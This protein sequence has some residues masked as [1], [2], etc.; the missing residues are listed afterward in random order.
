MDNPNIE[1]LLTASWTQFLADK[2]QKIVTK[3]PILAVRSIMGIGAKLILY[4]DLFLLLF[5]GRL[6]YTGVCYRYV[7]V[8]AAFAKCEIYDQI[9]IGYD[10]QQWRS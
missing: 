8:S 9:K 3:C 7:H 1:P 10:V 5:I 4:F 2:R 6:F